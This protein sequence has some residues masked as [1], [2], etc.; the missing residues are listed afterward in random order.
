MR[1][2]FSLSWHSIPKVSG[3]RVQGSGFRIKMKWWIM[4]MEEFII[5]V[6]CP[7]WHASFAKRTDILCFSLINYWPDNCQFIG[8]PEP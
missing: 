6:Y 7:Q 8:V 5:N 4:C 1:N 3:F 2:S